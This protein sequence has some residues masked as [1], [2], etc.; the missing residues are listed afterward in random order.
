MSSSTTSN[1]DQQTP[2][3]G[4]R[5]RTTIV[6]LA[7]ALAFAALRSAFVLVDES[8][9]VIVERLGH[10]VAVYDR[11]DDRGLHVK[12]PWPL[13]T[14]RRFDSRIQLLDPRGR[15]LFTRDK[16]NIT[17][18]SFICWRIAEA[19]DSTPAD[20]A[21]RP[22]V[23]FFKSLNGIEV[24]EA[25]LMTRVHSALSDELGRITLDTLLHVNDSEVGPDPSAGNPLETISRDV[26][27]QV[28][29]GESGQSL[30]ERLGV[31]IVDVRIKR[32]N[33][34]LGNQQAVFE[35]MRS[36]RQKIA[37]GYRSA[38]MAQNTVIRSQADRQYAEI[39]ARAN[40]DATRIRGQAE[41]ESIT[42][43][44][45]AHARD[46]EF[47]RLVQTLD[48]YKQILNERTTLVLSASSNLLKLLTDGPQDVPPKA[49]ETS[50][51]PAGA[52]P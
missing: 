10:I 51:P 7:A 28:R 4:K 45:K 18:D 36:E 30:R 33:F 37:D 47:H 27:Q 6:F 1:V 22:V 25:R 29:L 32:V 21:E 9:Y 5:N 14:T 41:A 8:E 52:A 24:A 20:F 12:L 3:A 34:P 13:S 49:P 26:R 50:T 43:L 38:G 23:R 16:K 2:R 15:E 46:P 40:A 19:D 42:I 48:S 17:V 35:R 39:L 44:N 31:E 11:P